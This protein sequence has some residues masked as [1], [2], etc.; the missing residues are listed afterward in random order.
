M[1]FPNLEFCNYHRFHIIF[2]RVIELV[3]K[4]TIFW[5]RF[6]SIKHQQTY[7]GGNV[8]DLVKIISLRNEMNVSHFLGG[9]YRIHPFLLLPNFKGY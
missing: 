7:K 3:F 6:V 5:K 2:V 4:L 1:S 9:V 8:S